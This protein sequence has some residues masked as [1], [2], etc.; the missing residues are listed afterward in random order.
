MIS[1]KPKKKKGNTSDMTP[2]IQ[3]GKFVAEYNF[4][5]FSFFVEQKNHVFSENYD[6]KIW[7]RIFPISCNLIYNNIFFFIFN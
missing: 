4:L 5:W 2:V 7:I 1:C 3:S 6:P